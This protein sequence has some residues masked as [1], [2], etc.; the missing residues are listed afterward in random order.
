MPCA[1]LRLAL[2]R[3]E[4]VL[5]LARRLFAQ[6]LRPARAGQRVGIDVILL[7][8]A[9][10]PFP[11]IGARKQKRVQIVRRV[12]QLR[13]RKAQ[14]GVSEPRR[15]LGIERFQRVGQRR[16][17]QQRGFGAVAHAVHRIHARRLKIRAA[18]LAAEAVQRRDIGALNAQRLF[19][20]PLLIEAFQ[21]AR[22]HFRRRRPRE[23]HHQHPVKRNAFLCKRHDARRQ[24][25]CFAATGRGG[26]EQIAASGLNGL[27]LRRRIIHG[28]APQSIRTFV[29]VFLR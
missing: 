16:L 1:E 27:L 14:R 12:F 2:S 23:R 21:N 24:H 9:F 3:C 19:A 6:R 4:R 28:E 10:Q 13:A 15:R 20:Q 22:A 8:R 26:H 25:G 11:R 17:L 18:D 5:Q 29:P 7:H